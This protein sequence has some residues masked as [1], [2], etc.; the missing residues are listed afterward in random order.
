MWGVDSDAL[1]SIIEFFYSGQCLLTF[2]GAIG[3]MD[4]ATRLDVP[5]LSAAAGSYVRAAL[6]PTTVSTI[7]DRAVRYKLHDL[8]GACLELIGDK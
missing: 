7:L 8:T 4:A 6:G 3:I 1:Q 5:T 2:P